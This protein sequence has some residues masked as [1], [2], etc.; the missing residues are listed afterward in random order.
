MS[1]LIEGPC[2]C[3]RLRR[4]ARIV[5]AFYD[6]VL[7]PSGLT[8]TQYALL[9]RIGRTRTL[10]RT[11]LAAQMGMERTTLTR[12]LAPL[13]RDGFVANVT[14]DDRREKLLSLTESGRQQVEF[15][16]PQWLEAQRRMVHHLGKRRWKQLH[17]LLEQSEG[18]LN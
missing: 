15:T 14:G 6:E 18:I 16:Y 17:A 10:S 3:G 13:E 7:A 9:A 4:T 12:N 8:V 2:I 5:S 1:K 11:E